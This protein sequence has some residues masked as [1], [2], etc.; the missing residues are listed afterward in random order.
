MIKVLYLTMKKSKREL[1]TKH[2][3][4]YLT[5]S[6]FEQLD[7]MALEKNMSLS[8]FIRVILR[9]YMRWAKSKK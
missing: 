7:T 2:V 9:E 4:T 8:S 5:D 1:H 6:D 3:A